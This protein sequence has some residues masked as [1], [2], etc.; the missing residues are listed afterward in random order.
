MGKA[1]KVSTS[2]LVVS[3]ITHYI[4]MYVFTYNLPFSIIMHPKAMWM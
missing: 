4:Q 2:F 1:R 3:E